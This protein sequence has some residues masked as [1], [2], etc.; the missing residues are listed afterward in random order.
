[1]LFNTFS[2]TFIFLPIV[3]AVSFTLKKLKKN[4]I[5]YC[6]LILS[7]LFFYSFL[8]PPYIFLIITSIL[9]NFYLAKILIKLYQ[10]TKRLI[11]FLIAIALNLSLLIYYKYFNFLIE[12][13]NFIFSLKIKENEIILPLAISFFTFQQIAFITSV[14]KNEIKEFKIIK[15][16]LFISFFPQLIAGP[17]VKFKEFYPQISGS[18]NKSNTKNFLILG[19]FVFSIG[20]LKKIVLSSYLSTFS[21]PVFHNFN[22]G[23]IVNPIDSW[24][25]LIAFSLQIYFDFSGYSD[26]AVGLALCLGIR[27]PIN[28]FSPY[29]AISFKDFWKR[30]HIT[31]SR[32]LKEHI[33][34]PL[35]G[36]K[37]GKIRSTYNILIT[38]ILG[39]IWHGA[40]WN[41]LL[42]GLYHGVLISIEKIVSA[43]PY[44]SKIK[45]NK[46]IK[47]VFIFLLI[48][49][50][51]VLFRCNDLA[52]IKSMT[53]S[54]FF[55]RQNFS[56]VVNH[57]FIINCFIILIILFVAFC[58]PNSCEIQ[59]N[60]EKRFLRKIISLL[61]VISL[62]FIPL[63]II[64]FLLS[65]PSQSINREFIY[66]QF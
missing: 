21:D 13:L 45:V 38:M 52:A 36:N 54:I 14:Y 32:F 23:I 56:L 53:S 55:I 44:F 9:F 11:L 37:I 60:I 41:F 16:F 61:K 51:W 63:V 34:I 24:M 12:N 30:W 28:F 33:Y 40:S 29:K 22:N 6:F 47:R 7:S 58:F 18:I 26:M 2:F 42:W 17:I 8:F 19:L 4:S 65:A 35:G 1:M 48:T 31:L 10:P 20:M 25:A 50:G 57:E 39:G 5:Y 43:I 27:L 62:L 64:F 3:L 59:N 66:F 15:Y 49:Y 46:A